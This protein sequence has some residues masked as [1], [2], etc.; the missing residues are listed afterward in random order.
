MDYQKALEK[1]NLFFL[2]RP[3]SP[4][5]KEQEIQKRPETTEQSLIGL[6]NDFRKN[7]LISDLLPQYIMD[8]ELFLK[9]HLLMYAGQFK[10]S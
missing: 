4:N 2:S 9:L 7:S 10:I 1:L 8:F 3:I 5:E 6:Q